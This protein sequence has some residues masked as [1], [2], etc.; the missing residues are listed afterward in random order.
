MT[1]NAFAVRGS[2]NA[3]LGLADSSPTFDNVL[4][5]RLDIQQGG[6]WAFASNVD[7]QT[8]YFLFIPGG[9]STPVSLS[10]TLDVQSLEIFGNY[11]FGGGN[12]G[13]TPRFPVTATFVA[14]L[15]R[16]EVTQDW[17]GTLGVEVDNIRIEGV[18]S[19]PEP[20]SL[21]L[22]GVS[23]LGLLGYGWRRRRRAAA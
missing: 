18:S 8:T 11:D 4:W 22:L 20:A 21:T 10:L 15:N 1:F 6:G 3:V 2:H 13:Q 5:W 17:R 12:T 14:A 16:I 19:V 23:T 7:G 9:F